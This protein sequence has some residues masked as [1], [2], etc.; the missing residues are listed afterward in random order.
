MLG[1]PVVS[2][3]MMRARSAH[4]HEVADRVLAEGQ[5]GSVEPT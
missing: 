5:D 1:L 3:P 4:G 2:S